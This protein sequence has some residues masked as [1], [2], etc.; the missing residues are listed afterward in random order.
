MA[1]QAAL[2]RIAAPPEAAERRFQVSFLNPS[3]SQT[4]RATWS[5]T[6]A[7]HTHTMSV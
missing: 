1:I 4:A 3:P 6:S 7:A 5:T 2:A